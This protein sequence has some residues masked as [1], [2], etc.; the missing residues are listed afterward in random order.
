MS[1]NIAIIG[2][3]NM[4]GALAKGF[5]KAMPDAQIIVTTSRSQVPNTEAVRNS[6][7]VILAVKPW[8]ID[9]VIEEVR[10]ELK[11]KI[12]ISVAANVRNEAIQV[13][14][15][16]NI[17]AEFG[18]TTTF[19]EENH[20]INA[21]QVAVDLFSTVGLVKVVNSKQMNAGLMMS[22]CGIAYIMRYL[23]ALTEG[24]VELGLKADDALEIAMQTMEGAVTLLRETGMHPEQAIDKVTTPG[25]VTIKGLN[26]L[27]AN[28]FSNAVI[29][30]LCANG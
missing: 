15:M 22:G 13:Y 18:E 8:L 17:A 12:V 1:M 4:G 21:T 16:P 14:T 9:E 25:G 29:K 3:G 23:R 27:E 26:A 30:G 20:N 7:I 11:N 2:G 28:G 6:D 19:I 24:G 10:H 5:A